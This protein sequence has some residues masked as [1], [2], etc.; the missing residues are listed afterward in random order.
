MLAWELSVDMLQS[1]LMGVSLTIPISNGRLALGTWQGIY[2]NEHRD[3]GGT[4]KIVVTMQGK[5]R[6]D[7]RKYGS[8][9]YWRAV[10]ENNLPGLLV[11]SSLLLFSSSG[12]YLWI[13]TD[14]F[15]NLLELR[16]DP[17]ETW[18]RLWQIPFQVYTTV[19]IV[20][21]W[22]IC[23]RVNLNKVA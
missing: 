8:S 19:I 22:F 18:C 2:L 1:S 4:R 15:W 7:G 11:I 23:L 12:C 20:D 14:C 10:W 17:C 16:L 6:S 21:N 3:Y 9:N 13:V 5:K